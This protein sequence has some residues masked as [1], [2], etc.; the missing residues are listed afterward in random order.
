MSTDPVW[1]QVPEL[2]GTEEG[3]AISLRFWI[4][5]CGLH[6]PLALLLQT[7]PAAGVLH[8]LAALLFGLYSAVSGRVDRAAQAAAYIAGAEVLWRMTG[9]SLF[10][11]FGKYALVLIFAATIARSPAWR[12]PPLPL[13]YFVVLLPSCLLT[14]LSLEAE[15]ARR[16]IS[17]NLSG[18][19]A[20]AVSVWF[21]ANCRLSRPECAQVLLAYVAPL[22]SVVTITVTATYLSG[23]IVFGT[24]S[25]FASSGGFGPNQVAS[26]LGLGV[27]F[28]VLFLALVPELALGG[29]LFL[30]SLVVLCGVQS[31]MTFSRSGLM[32]TL[33][34][35]LVGVLFLRRDP[36]VVLRVV[37]CAAAGY[38]L[39][40]GVVSPALDSFTGGALSRRFESRNLSHRDDLVLAD[41]AIWLENPVGGSGPGVAKS[42]RAARTHSSSI[43]HTEF[44]RL[45]SDHGLFGLVAMG[46]LLAMGLRMLRTAEAG[47]R[48]AF[49]AVM[50]TWSLVYMAVNGMRL[51]APALLLGLGALQWK[52]RTPG[53]RFFLKEAA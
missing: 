36:Q 39:V 18:P 47:G 31:A 14:L 40:A 4:A 43:A 2:A 35:G 45:L 26:S 9:A 13:A 41:L 16:Q 7:Q 32:L 52:A 3:Q 51:V 12:V 24:N 49:V 42:E 21:F 20:L 46:L 27:L 44:S 1:I 17:F 33:L 34:A 37:L 50:V 38:G 11:E 6:V 53:R 19:L 8:G 25:N 30:V 28:S 23:P 22:V 10:W 5:A 48:R 15:E 29:R